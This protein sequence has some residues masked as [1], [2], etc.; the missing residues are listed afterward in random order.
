MTT[1]AP[2]P[3]VRSS[4]ASVA[5]SPVTS[6]ASSTPIATPAARRPGIGSIAMIRCAPSRRSRK[7]WNSPTDPCP[8]TATVLP[9]SG[10][11]SLHP[12]TTVPSCWAMSRC[13]S[14]VSPGSLMRNFGSMSW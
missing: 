10:G 2:C 7:S 9:S 13:S 14:G 8:M 6:T 1:S 3:P 12:K 4:T 5:L 11:S